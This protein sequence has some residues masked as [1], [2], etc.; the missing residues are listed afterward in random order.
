MTNYGLIDYRD[1]SPADFAEPKLGTIIKELKRQNYIPKIWEL[2]LQQEAPDTNLTEIRVDYTD[3]FDGET[4][5]AIVYVI[6]GDAADAAAGTGARTVRVYGI[7]GDGD[8]NYEDFTLNGTTQVAGTTTWKRIIGAKV[9]TAGSGGVNAGAIQ[10]SNTGQTEVYATIA[11]G[12]NVTINARIY[13][14]ANYN[15]F[16]GKLEAMCKV[17][18]HAT[19]EVVY[20][21]GAIVA[22]FKVDGSVTDL[23]PAQYW[24][25]PD[26]PGFQDLNLPFDIIE[27]ADT[28]YVTLKHAAKAADANDVGIYRML[29]I[30]YGTTNTLRGLGA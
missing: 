7:D 2:I 11:A 4:S 5:A 25:N 12:E 8:P 6:S 18:P 21:T 17:S 3:E 16:M 1:P 19:D 15:A 27:G 28:Y 14:P 22:P 10:V 30:M 13:V 26:L 23:V 20:G 24:V 9:L 29:L